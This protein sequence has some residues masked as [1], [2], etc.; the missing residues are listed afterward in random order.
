M[1]TVKAVWAKKNTYTK[2]ASDLARTL[3]LSGLGIVWMFRSPSAHGS[4]I[5]PLLMWCSLL[6]VIALAL[7]LLQYLVGAYKVNKVAKHAEASGKHDNATVSYPL[8]HPKVMNRLWM[9]KIGFVCLAWIGL[10]IYIAY[11]SIN[12][13]L[14]GPRQEGALLRPARS[15]Q[16]LRVGCL[17]P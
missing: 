14:S 10:I 6:I 1:P 16:Y 4:A 3:C 8:S 12:E 5:P 9:I 11:K 15:R 7:D 13:T 2:G 17:R